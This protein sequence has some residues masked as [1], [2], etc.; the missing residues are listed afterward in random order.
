MSIVV[1]L[2]DEEGVVHLA[3]D[4]MAS[5]GFTNSSRDI[6]KVN[7]TR[8]GDLIIGI[9]GEMSLLELQYYEFLPRLQKIPG[10]DKMNER[11][12]EASE[13]F[14]QELDEY[15][16]IT[17]VKY[18]IAETIQ[19]IKQIPKQVPQN[20]FDGELLI[21]FQDQM[22][23]MFGDYAMVPVTNDFIVIGSGTYHGQAAMQMLNWNN[24]YDPVDKLLSAVT[25]ASDNVL[26]VGGTVYYTNTKDCEVQEL[27]LTEEDIQGG[28]DGNK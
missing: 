18:N 22:Y 6:C 16:F 20:H 10:S 12:E 25:V 13:I 8:D 1:G 28:E 4:S 24:D 26:S 19:G 5:N 21:A 14:R 3:S 7:P 17:E 11:L 15:D 9:V 2:R 27:V 23:T